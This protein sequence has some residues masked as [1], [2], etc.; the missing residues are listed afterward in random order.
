MTTALLVAAA[1]AAGFLFGGVAGVKAAFWKIGRRVKHLE[2]EFNG[3]V[4]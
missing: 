4:L 3:R 1:F 2:D